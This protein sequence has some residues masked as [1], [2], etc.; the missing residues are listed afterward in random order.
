MPIKTP[1]DEFDPFAKRSTI[2]PAEDYQK[3]DF[4]K[5]RAKSMD[6]HAIL[7]SGIGSMDLPPDRY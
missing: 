4:A 1:A 2:I 3:L 7:K 5:F 6:I